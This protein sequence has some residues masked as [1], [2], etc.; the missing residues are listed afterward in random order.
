M[1]IVSLLPSATEI[2]CALDLTGQLVGVTH[3]CDWPPIV[4]TLPRVTHTH[5][6]TE[7][8]SAEID[9]LVRGQIGDGHALYSLNV[10]ELQRLRPDL[11]ITQSLCGVCAVADREV[12][13]AAARLPGAPRVLRLEPTRLREVF[14]SIIDV[15]D[16]AGVLPIGKGLIARLAERV[17]RVQA[18]VAAARAGPPP[19]V[20]LLEWLDPPVSCG[21]WSPELIELAGGWELLGGAGEPSR[22][23]SH[24]QIAAADP[25][26][27]LIACCGQSADRARRDVPAFCAQPEI[28]TLRCIRAGRIHVTD[29]N[30]FF[31]RPGPRLVDALEWLAETLAERRAANVE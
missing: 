2:V 30:A 14:E 17:E 15:A 7:A 11:I 29:G 3:E 8:T 26:V 20:V 31:S 9:G 10:A 18:A 5:I 24:A 6:P 25:D 19:R 22:R 21:H 13:E 4:R 28:A 1:R 27:L 16:A 12:C 23:L